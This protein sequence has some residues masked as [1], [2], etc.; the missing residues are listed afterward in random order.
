MPDAKCFNNHPVLQLGIGMM[1][2]NLY[3]RNGECPYCGSVV[4]AHVVRLHTPFECPCCG[5]ALK[6]HGIYELLIRLIAVVIGLFVAREIGLESILLFCI[7]L[8]ISLF[9]VIPIWRISAALKRPP[10]IP[11]SP[12]VTTLHLN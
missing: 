2:R 12:A 10:L 7:G 4:P 9:L 6:V 11:S 1:K 8:M 3:S 5:K